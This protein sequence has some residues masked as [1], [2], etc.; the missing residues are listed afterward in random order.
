M[1]RFRLIKRGYGLVAISSMEIGLPFIRM[2]LMSRWLSLPELG[3]ASALAS[4]Y[5]L[6]DQITDIAIYRYVYS[7][8]REHYEDAL[9]AAHALSVTR[10]VIVGALIFALSPLIAAAFSLQANWMDFAALSGIIFIRSFEHLE[11]RVAERDYNFG[12]LAKLTFGANSLSFAGL[13]AGLALLHDHRALTASLYGLAIGF[14]IFSHMVARTPYRLAFLTPQFRKAFN[15]GYPLMLNGVGLAVSAQGDRFLVGS[16]LG[17]A[18]LGVYS[19]AML[20]IIVP[21][22]MVYRIMSSITSATLYNASASAQNMKKILALTSRVTPMIAA[23]YAIGVLCLANIVVPLVF[24]PQ[25]RV[26]QYAVSLLAVG[27]FL[28]IARAEPFNSLLLLAQH[29]KKIALGSLSVVGGLVFGFILMYYHR[30]I[31]AALMGR[32]LGEALNLGVMLVMTRKLLQG[33][34]PDYYMSFATALVLVLTASLLVFLTPVGEALAPSLLAVA[35]Y[36]VLFA[37]WGFLAL[38]PLLK[39]AA[40]PIVAVVD[41]PNL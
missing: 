36:A 27:A 16:M 9:A 3:F 20:A 13:V 21:I 25:F 10:G 18:E 35:G 40:T 15:F 12:S 2:M 8:P 28:R 41:R 1:S 29:T 4:A 39:P 22:S 19:V 34:G 33:A 7:E 37:G 23:L 5:A 32:A 26:S 11:S 24:G 14:A 17:M 30:S 38:L 6:F 31:D